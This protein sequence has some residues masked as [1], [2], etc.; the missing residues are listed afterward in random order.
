MS[1]SNAGSRQRP[2][3]RRRRPDGPRPSRSRAASHRSG[4][5][6]DGAGGGGGPTAPGRTCPPPPRG[7]DRGPTAG[8]RPPAPRCRSR[9]GRPVPAADQPLPELAVVVDLAVVVE[10]PSP[11]RRDHGLGALRAQLDHRQPS[12]TEGHTVVGVQPEPLGVGSPV[13]EGRGHG[14]RLAAEGSAPVRRSGSKS[15]AIPHTGQTPPRAAG[16]ARP[17][18]GLSRRPLARPC[19]DHRR[20][21]R[22][23]SSSAPVR[24]VAAGRRRPSGPG[25]GTEAGSCEPGTRVASCCVPPAPRR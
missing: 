21:T 14:C 10:Y 17:G 23:V 4:P 6:P 24:M 7:P 16:T 1:A 3:A 11:V 2:S 8:P 15:P 9:R 18:R 13:G 19:R 12:V 5:G 20:C 25:P 22:V